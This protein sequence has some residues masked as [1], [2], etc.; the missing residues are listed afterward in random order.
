[1]LCVFTKPI[2]VSFSKVEIRFILLFTLVLIPYLGITQIRMIIVTSEDN[3]QPLQYAHVVN[4][5][6]GLGKITDVSGMVHIESRVGDTLKVS[7]VGYEQYTFDIRKDQKE[8]KVRLQLQPMEEVVVFAE[9][10]FNRRAAEGRQDVPMEMLVALPAFNGDPDIMKAI[11]FLPGVSG[12]KDGYS[13]F[14]VRGGGQDEN[15][16][17]LDGA[18]LYNVNHFGGFVSMFHSDLIQSVNFYKGYWPSQF[19]GRLSSVMDIGLKSG[20]FKKHTFSGD[21]S[22]LSVKGH[23]SGDRKS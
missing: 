20:D 15:L 6:T 3:G 12:G 5:R 18:P 16:I 1:M 2:P 17:L 10:P 13:H 11:T 7:F 4:N 9:E 14:F 21:F 8:Y 23:I 22:P 19:G